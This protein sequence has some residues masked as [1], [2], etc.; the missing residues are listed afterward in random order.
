MRLA[1]GGGFR[2]I[3]GMMLSEGMPTAAFGW[4]DWAIVAAYFVVTT[5][6]GAKLSGKQA[7]IRDFFL[8]GRKLPWW[9][10]SGSIVAAEISAATFIAV[11]AISYAAGGDFT[12]LQLGIGA[13][14]ARIVIGL[15][16]VPR[17]YEREIYS[18]YDFMGHQLGPRVRSATTLLFFVGGT[19]GQGAR[20]LITAFLLREVAGVEIATAILCISVFGVAWA[21]IGG[22]TTVIWTDVAQF[23]ILMIGALAALVFAVY[24]VD[25]GAD[26]VLRIARETDKLNVI[27]ARWNLALN[28]SLWV[29]LLSMP[30][31]NVAA[32]GLDQSIAQR[33]FCCKT[34]RQATIAI[35]AS[36]LGQTVAVLMLFVG[37]SIFAYFVHHPPTADE[38]TRIADD[39][40]SVF[41]VYIVRAVPTGLRGLLVAAIFAASMCS[42]A[43]SALSQSTMSAFREP[44]IQLCRRVGLVRG[45]APGDVALSRVLIVF[46]GVVLALVAVACIPIRK[47]YPNAIDLVLNVVAYT[48]GPMLGIFLLAF[49][50]IGR[51]DAGLMWAVPLAM[52]AVFGFTVHGS[53]N[54]TMLG[55]DGDLPWADW[56]VWAGSGAALLM[57][58]LRFRDDLPRI[59]VITLAALAIVM[60]HHAR[61]GIRPDGGPIFPSPYWAYPVGTMVT[62]FVGWGLGRPRRGRTAKV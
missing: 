54:L 41:P 38:A 29:G 43:L 19:L 58:L 32:F 42:S 13:I 47:H 52:L 35:I 2:D 11:P 26:E 49:F 55:I 21:F 57:A 5:V 3:A 24:S 12:Y 8:G 23:V 39:A 37:V 36:S 60:L 40:T 1:N 45:R 10:V 33:M 48:Y 46:W 17:F 51:D 59:A 16:F 7:T 4:I 44:V 34:P 25:G 30:F 28:Y 9:A 61:A 50:P 27:D 14:I 53:I 6:V 62:L 18:P 15:Y 20:I 56:V 22:I 31:L